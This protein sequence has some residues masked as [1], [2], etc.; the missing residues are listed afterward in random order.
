M[1]RSNLQNIHFNKKTPES[2]KKYKKQKHCC[3]KL[4]KKTQRNILGTGLPSLSQ[5]AR[6]SRIQD[7]THAHTQQR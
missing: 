1:K 7:Q 3:S 4:Y 5:F 6:V 2:L